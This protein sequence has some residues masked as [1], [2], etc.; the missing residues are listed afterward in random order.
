[1][2]EEKENDNLPEKSHPGTPTKSHAYVD[3]VS[4]D[5][6]MDDFRGMPVLRIALFTVIIHVA[7]VGVF[8]VG[9]L[10]DQILGEDTS[11]LTDDERMDR[12]V[13]AGTTELRA[14]AE[15][16][17]VSVQDLSARF[18]GDSP[19]P[20][21]QTPSSEDPESNPVDPDAESPEPGSEIERALQEKQP[22][23][24]VPDLTEDIEEEDP[25]FPE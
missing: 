12:A 19:A 4:P 1:M 8:S 5:E 6:V 9:Y 11:S 16:Y 2:T 15:R 14:I 22:G 25:I 10:K 13:R 21:V 17:D 18:A 20:V 23:P 3:P 7:L 24:A